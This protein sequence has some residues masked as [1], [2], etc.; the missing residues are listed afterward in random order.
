MRTK[1]YSILFPRFFTKCKLNIFPPNSIQNDARRFRVGEQGGMKV[2]LA[3]Q[4]NMLDLRDA[5]PSLKEKYGKFP[6]EE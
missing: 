6:F 3:L 4:R 5:H 2:P 1:R